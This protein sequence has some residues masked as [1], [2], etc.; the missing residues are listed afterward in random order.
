MATAA[1]T[2][3]VTG[4][5]GALGW[6]GWGWRLGLAGAGG[7]GIFL[8]FPRFDQWYLAWFGLVPILWAARGL[9]P[10]RRFL[11]GLWA[12]TITN[13][14]GFYWIVGM[15]M[16]FG[17][18]AAWAAVPIATLLWVYQ[19][20]VFA[21]WL[22]LWALL[23]RRTRLG[24]WLLAPV[25]F[26]VAEFGVWF[27]FPWYYANSQH[28]VLPLIQVCELGGVGLLG[29]AL[30]A[31][32]GLLFDALG[33][34]RERRRAALARLGVA[35]AVPLLLAGYGWLRMAQV[36]AAAEA[37]PKLRIGLVEAD[38]GIWEKEDPAKIR[39][40]LVLHQRLSVELAAR[41]A[42]LIVWPETSFQPP[43]AVYRPAGQEG[44]TRTR[45]LS[46]DVAEIPQSPSVPPAHADEDTR[47][48]TRLEDIVAPQRGFSTPLLFGALT[49]RRNPDARHARHP[50]L[51]LL[52]S[53]I[54]LDGQGKVLGTYD[55]VY[56]LMFGEYIPLGD[57]FP[58]FYEWL[59]EAGSLT[60]GDRVAVLPFGRF[61]LG[62]MVC[63]EDILLAFSR[64]LANQ[65]PNVLINVT[66]DAWFGKTAEPYL[67]LALAIFRTVESRLPLIRST[68][69]G[70]SCFVDPVGRVTQ[71]TS[72]EGAETLLE[73]VPMMPP[74][75]T[76]YLALGD[77][78]AYLCF[79]ALPALWWWGRRRAAPAA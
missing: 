2:E 17:H 65:R 5:G 51:D 56:L 74:T 14:G 50:G 16:D 63:Y 41:G 32:N 43:L 64:E 29:F 57:H 78:P 20:L 61:R 60:R 6:R 68:N 62:V 71:E 21:L 55:K 33:L 38:V 76:P 30:L 44:L 39:D 34:W 10:R 22:L 7:A 12:G 31:V 49:F 18:L 48:G 42:E 1:T 59:P 79:L 69:T 58:V 36:D 25:C 53:A 9:S 70:V 40:N 52:N 24:A 45:V 19:G 13:T 11:L 46:R 15:L 54:L 77:W 4:G 66:N 47:A 26:L 73:D 35:L 8:A 23:E 67:H 72:L 27:L 37:A 75:A 3:A 28:S